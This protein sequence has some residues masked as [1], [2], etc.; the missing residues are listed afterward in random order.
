MVDVLNVGACLREVMKDVGDYFVV[1]ILEEVED[2]D[3][4]FW[5]GGHI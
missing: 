5:N 2:S 3:N 1:S 4:E